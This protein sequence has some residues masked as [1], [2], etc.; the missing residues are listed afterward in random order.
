VQNEEQRA[1]PESAV[2]R[3]LEA[4]LIDV[5][6]RFDR[7]LEE[8][9]PDAETRE[10]WRRH[11]DNHGPPPDEPP[12]IRPLVFCGRNEAGSTVE[13][14]RRSAA[15]LDVEID[16]ALAERIAADEE[17]RATTVPYRLRLDGMAIDETFAVPPEALEA[18]AG[19]VADGGAPPWEHF[20]A[21]YGDGVVGENMALTPR[22]RRALALQAARSAT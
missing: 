5:R 18:L 9:V 11:L 16:G 12:A 21:L 4:R 6:E 13:I 17:L 3:R 20:E 7:R 15:E 1:T 2:R 19:F 14:R 8:W 10:A 22:G